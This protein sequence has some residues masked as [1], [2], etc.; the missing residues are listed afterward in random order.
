DPNRLAADLRDIAL[1]KVDQP[2]RHRQQR[3]HAARDKVFA[4]AEADDQ[5]ARDARHYDT[6]GI[7][8]VEYEQRVRA[9]EAARREPYGLEQVV[10]VLQILVDEMRGNLRVGLR[11]ELVALRDQLVLDRL[12]VLDDA[13]VNQRDPIAREVRVRVVLRHAA[14][15]RPTRMRDPEPTG[16]WTLVELRLELRDFADGPA[17]RDAAVRLQDGEPGRVIAAIFESPQALEKD[18]NDV[19]FGD[20]SDYSAHVRLTSCFSRAASSPRSSSDAN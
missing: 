1:L 20:G 19:P 14:V 16:A 18:G 3:G 12:E 6:I 2:L 9:N 4:D 10:A 15:R 7:E 8:R 5:R 13:V 11:L 17:Q